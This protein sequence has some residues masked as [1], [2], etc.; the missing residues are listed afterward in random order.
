MGLN[1][2]VVGWPKVDYLVCKQATLAFEEIK[3][4]K[5]PLS[6][7]KREGTLSKCVTECVRNSDVPSM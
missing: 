1:L 4:W 5:G 7:M 6:V 2:S 3:R